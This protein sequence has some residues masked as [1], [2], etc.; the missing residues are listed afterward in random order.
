[1][2]VRTS[3]RS[4]AIVDQLI[5]S[6]LVI[7]SP[8]AGELIFGSYKPNAYKQTA[9][10]SS[11]Y[12]HFGTKGPF[13]GAHNFEMYK[14]KLIDRS[15]NHNY[16]IQGGTRY[17]RSV[18]DHLLAAGTPEAWLDAG[19]RHPPPK[20]HPGS[21]R[22]IKRKLE[23]WIFKLYH[24][25]KIVWLRGSAGVGKSAIAQ[26]FAELAR[27]RGRLGAA[28][29]FFALDDRRSHP[30]RLV[31][32]LAFQLAVLNEPYKQ[33]LTHLLATDPSIL[34]AALHIQFQKLIID[35][36]SLLAS[37]SQQATEEPYLVIIDGLDE[38]ND[39]RAQC[40][41]V[42]L[43]N[44]AAQRKDVPLLWLVCSRPE[45]HLK[46]TFSRPDY[47]ILY[48]QQE[49]PIDDETREDVDRYLRDSFKNIL[50][51]HRHVI[52]VPQDGCWPRQDDF[53]VIS[54]ASS[55][56]FVFASAVVRVVDD[57]SISDPKIQLKSLL[58]MLKDFDDIGVRNPL[59]ALDIFYTRIL[60][61]VP[62]HILPLS[63]H[64]LG[65]YIYQD[66]LGLRYLTAGC[67]QFYCG[68]EEGDFVSAMQK[69][70]SVVK[71]PSPEDAPENQLSFY[72]RS[73]SDHLRSRRRS[74]KYHL[75]LEKFLSTFAT[76]GL[77]VYNQIL[78]WQRPN[79]VAFEEHAHSR[80]LL[81]KWSSRT[82][83]TLPEL[84][85]EVGV[86][87]LGSLSRVERDTDYFEVIRRFNF[88][89]LEDGYDVK[90]FLEAAIHQ[91]W[92]TNIGKGF[93]RTNAIDEVTDSQLFRHLSVL[94]GG[95]SIRPIDITCAEPLGGLKPYIMEY[96]ILGEGSKSCLICLYGKNAR[97]YHAISLKAQAPP[98]TN[99]ISKFR[100]WEKEIRR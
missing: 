34:Y 55:G 98:S 35:P 99:E 83:L 16:F 19:A 21:R 27:E 97:D 74:G 33:A 82:N 86:E 8:S 69:L 85:A 4:P 50:A 6:D 14:T 73:F 31:P 24:Q 68:I 77:R 93:I 75:P 10:T 92:N 45:S 40:E 3:L 32:S 1:M 72:H 23:E 47:S 30:L 52:A 20:C 37:H 84:E 28:Y 90:R 42:Q 49:L 7:A 15:C 26:T 2:N 62:E 48:D 89:L 67:I 100:R 38:C 11:Q 80:T 12:G 61:K 39:E 43:I 46:Y 58:T 25:Q 76:N 94:T 17:L 81:D 71:V 79:L 18:L 87:A 65:F 41:L 96:A 51:S 66:H 54:R 5:L 60:S 22:T 29:F 91:D 44:G 59:Q 63:T 95:K 13:A 70:H 56:L 53:D 57:S 64:I 88:S 9:M 78:A 36:F